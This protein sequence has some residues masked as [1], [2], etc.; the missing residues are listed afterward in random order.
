MGR[1]LLTTHA[2]GRIA[3]RGAQNS[4]VLRAGYTA[5]ENTVRSFGRILHLLFLQA[6]GLLF[7]LFALGLIAGMPRIYHEQV[8]Q[9]HGP[10]R[11]Y[12][13]A[14]MSLMFL[15][16]GLTSFWRARRK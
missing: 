10:G 11:L 5:A 4:R 14:V 12:L 13:L 1:F 3:A 2:I 15:W 6:V 16:F 7:C 8:T 9:K